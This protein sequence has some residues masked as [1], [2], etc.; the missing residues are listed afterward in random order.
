MSK[1]SIQYIR[2]KRYPLRPNVNQTLYG[3]NALEPPYGLAAAQNA[4]VECNTIGAT[5]MRA[6]IT[7]SNMQ[8]T[9]GGTITWTQ[10]DAMLSACQAASPA[11][12]PIF[13]FETTPAWANGGLSNAGIP[14][15]L[16]PNWS[17]FV[18]FYA[19]WVTQVVTRYGHSVLYEFWN[20]MGSPGSGFWKE[21][22]S[23][24]TAPTIAAYVAL[25]NACYAAAKAVDPAITM[26]TGGLTALTHWFGNDAIVGVEYLRQLFQVYSL[27][28]DA[29][30]I[31]PYTGDAATQN[32]ST[33]N[34]GVFNGASPAA[35]SFVDIARVQQLM[36]SCGYGNTPLWVTECFDISAAAA[37][38][39][40]IKASWWTAGLRKI[41]L[42][43]G[44]AAV[45]PG[46]A[47]V[48]IC[49][50]YQ[51]NNNSDGTVDTNDT[52]L[53]TGTP[54]GGP[55]TILASGTAYQT[56]IASLPPYS[57]SGVTSVSLF[58]NSAAATPMLLSTG[59]TYTMVAKDQSGNVLSG[60]GTW[61][62]TD[63]TNAP[64]NSSTGV[65]S[66]AAGIG[67][68]TITYTH[69]ASGK[70]ATVLFSVLKAPSAVVYS[71][72]GSN[73][74]NTAALMANIK[75]SVPSDSGYN[76]GLPVAT[77]SGS[78]LYGDGVSA[79]HFFID[80][81]TPGRQFMGGASIVQI[82]PTV[83]GNE[84]LLGVLN[85][86]SITRFWALQ[87]IRFDPGFTM[88]GTGGGAAAYKIG[89]WGTIGGGNNSGRFGAE[90]TNG[91][92][93]GGTGGNPGG[94]FALESVVVVSGTTQ[95]G[96]ATEDLGFITTEFY[97]GEYWCSL[98]LYEVRSNNIMS[99]RWGWWKIGQV[100][101][102]TMTT[103]YF[104]AVEGPMVGGP[105][106][107]YAPFAATE[108]Q[109]TGANYNQ[110]PPV[111]SLYVSMPLWQVVNGDTYGD[112]YGILADTSTPTLTGISG[113]TVAHG[114]SNNSIVLTGTNFN[115]NCWPI[116]SSIY[117]FA[118]S[119]TINSSTQMTVVVDVNSGA[120]LGA[121]TVK[122]HNGASTNESST[123]VVTIT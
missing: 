105:S 38:S 111:S 78:A 122:I 96:A 102:M 85:A 95:G 71:D 91:N 17:A 18:T 44:A 14:T 3:I 110:T 68:G 45:G 92:S 107:S 39:E 42:L 4:A 20:E 101:N 90:L 99:S 103:N 77:G 46:K 37:G 86:A 16:G 93:S 64:V 47:G 1:T 19:A 94:Q 106:P 88:V 11:I 66:P 7:W 76:S 79:N 60:V 34:Y 123:Q 15:Y 29:V 69:T 82:I 65:I 41:S 43:Y 120:T 100:P 63:A 57:A 74:A 5:V 108:F 83:A 28:C 59:T 22:D 48:T 53:F 118:Q 36:I 31:H 13:V 58:Y 121:G 33:D 25:F 9:N 113:G 24:T 89:N 56:F 6:A 12:T 80:S 21:N 54:L 98:L 32:P 8:T 55:N 97:A 109:P 72:T 51:L 23:T 75:S 61:S 2:A 114:S 73:Y 104:T 49:C 112:P 117:V 35:N 27:T 50:P 115:T 70:T 119:I 10:P 84:G 30:S 40:A 62:T 67:G 116:F 26:S 87:V 81:T 52:G